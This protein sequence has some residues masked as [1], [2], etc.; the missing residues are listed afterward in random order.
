L[1]EIKIFD[2]ETKETLI[3]TENIELK[4]NMYIDIIPIEKYVYVANKGKVLFGKTEKFDLET[5]IG[6]LGIDK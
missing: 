4:N 5:L 1:S 3:A 2:P 6:K